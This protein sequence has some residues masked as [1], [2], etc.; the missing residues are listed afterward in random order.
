MQRTGHEVIGLK[1]RLVPAK[2]GTTLGQFL[3]AFATVV[4]ILLY[5]IRW[6]VSS[7]NEDRSSVAS[8]IGRAV[9]SVAIALLGVFIFC[10]FVCYDH[11]MDNRDEW[12]RFN[13]ILRHWLELYW[14]S[15][16][17]LIP[18]FVWMHGSS[19][20]GLRRIVG[21]VIVVG[22]VVFGLL[23]T[24]SVFHARAASF[25]HPPTVDGLAFLAASYPADAAVVRELQKAEYDNA[26][27]LELCGDRRLP[28]FDASFS[29]AGRI[30]AYSGRSSLCGWN[31]HTARYQVTFVPPR[32]GFQYVWPYLE[33]V[34]SIS[35]DVIARQQR[36]SAELIEFG[37]TH[38]A[39]GSAEVEQFG[40][41]DP[42]TFGELTGL[43]PVFY[44][45][46]SGAAIYIPSR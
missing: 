35:F 26:V 8:R 24:V 1:W 37:V 45:P 32:N 33:K 40:K 43:R 29:R 16:I 3:L 36:R 4:P 17:L 42:K 12:R 28:N 46:E 41:R 25:R 34:S 19:A 13:P 31:S 7:G 23:S 39:Y 9:L 2:L 14:F 11:P 30:A 27:L 18:F 21:F 20:S 44:H 15:P 22:P 38:V 5:F 10:E 6:G